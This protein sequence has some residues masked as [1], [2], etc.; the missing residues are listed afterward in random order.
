[1]RGGPT[2][3][4]GADNVAR[5][6]EWLMST[7][8]GMPRVK[9]VGSPRSS[10]DRVVSRS[11]LFEAHRRLAALPEA[12]KAGNVSLATLHAR[13]AARAREPD[14]L[15]P[16]LRR[17]IARGLGRKLG[18]AA[19]SA[20]VR[21][22]VADVE[23]GRGRARRRAADEARAL[24]AQLR[25]DPRHATHARAHA[26][27]ARHG[28]PLMRELRAFDAALGLQRCRR[29]ARFE[30][31]AREDAFELA[32]ALTPAPR[33]GRCE[34]MENLEWVDARGKLVGEVDVVVVEKEPGDGGRRRALVLL[35]LK[36]HLYDVLGGFVQQQR[37]LDAG[38]VL[39]RPDAAP[40]LVARRRSPSAFRGG[41]VHRDASTRV[42]VVTTLPPH[43]Y[44]MGAR[45]GLIQRLGT[46]FGNEYRGLNPRL[47]PHERDPAELEG[48]ARELLQHEADGGEGTKALAACLESADV[49]FIV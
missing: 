31:W 8:L 29:G 38:N 4:D 12:S 1:M 25:A 32:R 3:D 30:T 17:K 40:E 43:R 14:A 7:A 19:D 13:R 21:A 39:L 49:L 9:A 45:M 46:H 37:Q 28:A 23:R 41:V 34:R 16:P 22:R 18:L 36:S 6:V 15:P 44:V 26:V 35:E 48:I 10:K 20:R 33:N 2:N 27:W 24:L 42:L 5:D 11:D 47:V